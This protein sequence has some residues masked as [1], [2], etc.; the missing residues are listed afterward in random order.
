MNS[1]GDDK[2][3]ATLHLMVGLPGSG[4]TTEALRLEKEH[5]ALRL[6]TDEWHYR[7]FGNDFRND[8]KD[9]EHNRR[10]AA[11]EALMRET[12][13]RVLAL[14]VDV[15]LDFGCWAKEER[16]QLRAEA[17]AV[18]AKF[19]IHYQACSQEELWRRLQER[20]KVVGRQAVFHITENNLKEWWRQFEPPSPEELRC[21]D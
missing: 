7:L 1:S 20:N 9:E 2:H 10:H 4:K 17:H 14:G 6:T 13:R 12:A 11:I 16:D 21:D 5:R 3:M 15:I 8:G 18:G 19:R